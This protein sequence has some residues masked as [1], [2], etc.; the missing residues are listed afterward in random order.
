M[1]ADL[2]TV[3]GELCSTYKEACL[4]MQLLDDDTEWVNC[5][6]EAAATK[7]PKTIRQ[8]FLTILLFCQPADI[9]SLLAS[10]KECMS[11]D[12][13]RQRRLQGFQEERLQAVVDNDLACALHEGLQDLGALPSDFPGLPQADFHQ[14]SEAD[15]GQDD[16]DPDAAETFSRNFLL[17]NQEQREV[18]HAIQERLDQGQG[19]LFFIDA[20]GKCWYQVSLKE[21]YK[22]L[23]QYM[24]NA[25][26]KINQYHNRPT[27]VDFV[28]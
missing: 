20:P 4:R 3:D 21:I 2:R 23:Y 16:M 18:F 9:P 17:L 1:C 5:I 19:G 28:T 27:N 15:I 7:A 22:L 12:F 13:N 6:T 25:Q 14:R 8:L 26:I 24:I 10:S 11:E